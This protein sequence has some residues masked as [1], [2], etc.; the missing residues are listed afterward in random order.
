M[1]PQGKKTNP[2]P[3]TL[4]RFFWEYDQGVID[5]HDHADLIMARLMARGNRHSMAWLRKMYPEKQISDF[6]LRKGW[7]ILPLREL[8]YWSLVAGL[9]D[10][11]KKKLLQK[12][13]EADVIWRDRLVH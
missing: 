5:V 8:N 6:L 13:R 9:A 2:L 12:A 4:Y 7:K 3:D 11:E 10:G 1:N